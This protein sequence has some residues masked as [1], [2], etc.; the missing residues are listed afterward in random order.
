MTN[1][2]GP[3]LP[4]CYRKGYVVSILCGVIIVVLTIVLNDC[5][6]VTINGLESAIMK[7]GVR[8]VCVA[9]VVSVFYTVVTMRWLL[10]AGWSPPSVW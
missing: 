3:C 7:K 10:R 9:F 5:L 4:H 6:T 8:T 1:C 2:S